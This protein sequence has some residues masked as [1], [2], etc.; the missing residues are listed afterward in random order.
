M[1]EKWAGIEL[2]APQERWHDVDGR[3]VQ[4]WFYPARRS[5]RAAPVVLEIHGGPATL[6]GWSLMWEWQCSSPPA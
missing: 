1:G 4:G 6:Y 5:A 2:V 3:R